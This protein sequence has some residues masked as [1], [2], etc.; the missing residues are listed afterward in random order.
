VMGK[1]RIAAIRATRAEETSFC[2]CF[3]GKKAS[4]GW[5]SGQR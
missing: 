2:L 3:Q 4:V 5:E 1:E